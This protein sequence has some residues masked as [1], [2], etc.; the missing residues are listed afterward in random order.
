[1][2]VTSLDASDLT[3]VS[4]TVVGFIE[5]QGLDVQRP[6]LERYT[7]AVYRR[8]VHQDPPVASCGHE[9][10]DLD[11]AARCLRRLLRQVTRTLRQE[12]R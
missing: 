1:M 6:S 5:A 9:H 10:R 2:I 12:T 4:D 11:Q 8:P 3:G 7:A